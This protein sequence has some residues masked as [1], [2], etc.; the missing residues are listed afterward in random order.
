[1]GFFRKLHRAVVPSYGNNHRPHLLRHHV[2][3]SVLIFSVLIEAGVLFQSLVVFRGAGMLTAVLP[4]VVAALTNE[5][6]AKSNTGPLTINPLLTK[7]AEEKASDM[8]A[9]GYFSHLSPDG[10][11]PWHWIESVGYHYQYAGENLA[12]NFTDSDELLHAWLASPEHRANILKPNYTDIGIGMAVGLYKGREAV[13]VVQYFASPAAPVRTPSSPLAK[14]PVAA[15]SPAPT[16]LVPS[17]SA[18]PSVLG[19]SA[20]APTL[21]S[22]IIRPAGNFLVS[23]RTVADKIL[24]VLLA[25]FLALFVLGSLLGSRVPHPSVIVNMLALVVILLGIVLINKHALP[26]PIRLAPDS[27]NAAVVRAF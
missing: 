19:V 10:T 16:A 11:L 23:P 1:M 20:Q 25:F 14:S 15:V 13:F 12:V 4:G 21:K 3:V 27:Q 9:K 17:T 2:I 26:G 24:L 22:S 8:V 7:A 5:A 6:R 18:A